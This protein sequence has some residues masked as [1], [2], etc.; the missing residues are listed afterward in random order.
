MAGRTVPPSARP[1]LDDL[2]LT[3]EK[4]EKRRARTRKERNNA[5]MPWDG[6][7]A[8]D[9]DAVLEPRARA[10]SGTIA[11]VSADG[12]GFSPEGADS[13]VPEAVVD[14]LVETV[15][16]FPGL[17]VSYARLLPPKRLRF[18]A[19][20]GPEESAELT[21]RTLRLDDAPKYLE[22]L[23]TALGSI[24]IEDAR[25]DSRTKGIAPALEELDIRA[26]LAL[27]VRK[28]RDPQPV[29][30]VLLDSPKPRTWSP[31][32]SAALDR[33]GPIIAMALDNAVLR[34]HLQRAEMSL[35]E[36]ER[37]LGAVRGVVGGVM[38]D[39]DILV[40]A[41]MEAIS[42]REGA[43]ALG[44]Q[45][46]GVLSEL[47]ILDHGTSRTH[48]PIDL[49]QVITQLV[50]ALRALVGSEVRLLTQLDSQPLFVSGHLTGLE[51]ALINIVVHGR[52]NGPAGDALI[53]ET[54]LRDGRAELV[55]RGDGL[56]M[57]ESMARLRLGDQNE[58]SIPDELGL[59]LWLARCEVLLHG[60]AISVS[61]D[62]AGNPR[63][64]VSFPLL[65]DRART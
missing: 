2:E 26:L 12:H 47:S 41:L 4:V 24:G 8:D 36:Y 3:R 39:T 48:Q 63:I 65:D 25:T 56:G 31:K 35:S 38:H 46:E 37:R 19:C 21:G 13:P 58:A 52:N 15:W 53:F 5:D 9:F 14:A 57:D 18:M 59:G 1:D 32:E 54:S 11:S 40:R 42:H 16:T 50:P 60:G 34:D 6:E 7:A 10:R 33:L 20:A 61:P 22:A 23:K 43:A 29:G 27:P 17:R 30:V 62:S 49:N 51:R 55:I 44:R 28:R 64:S 45:L